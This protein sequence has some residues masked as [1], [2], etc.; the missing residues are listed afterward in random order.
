MVSRPSYLQH[1][2]RHTWE[3]WSLYWDRALVMHTC[4]REW[5]HPH[6]FLWCLIPCSVPSQWNFNQNTKR[7]WRCHWFCSGLNVLATLQNWLVHLNSVICS[8]CIW[9]TFLCL[10]SNI[11]KKNNKVYNDIIWLRCY[12]NMMSQIAQH[13]I[14]LWAGGSHSHCCIT[15]LILSISLRYWANIK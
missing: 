14:F 9:L 3:R 13:I 1:G 2:N 7:I 8:T 5:S 4:N 12:V 6:E 10:I 15:F 11:H